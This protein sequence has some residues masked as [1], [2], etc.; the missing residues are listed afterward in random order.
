MLRFSLLRGLLLRNLFKVKLED[1]VL[2]EEPPSVASASFRLDKDKR[3]SEW[4]RRSS[5]GLRRPDLARRSAE[6]ALERVGRWRK[7]ASS[8]LVFGEK[9][10]EEE[11]VVP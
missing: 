8:V 6:Y 5:A 10:E 1:G 2:V 4:A 9:I 7:S 3:S 11:E